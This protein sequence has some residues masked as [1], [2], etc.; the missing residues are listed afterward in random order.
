VLFQH[1][2]G[3]VFWVMAMVVIPALFLRPKVA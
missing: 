2:H 3:G 1:L